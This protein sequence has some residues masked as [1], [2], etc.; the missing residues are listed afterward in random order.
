MAPRPQDSKFTG[1]KDHRAQRKGQDSKN[2]GLKGNKVLNS[3]R[4]KTKPNHVY[5]VLS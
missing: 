2:T 1:L 5:K 4:F 3:T